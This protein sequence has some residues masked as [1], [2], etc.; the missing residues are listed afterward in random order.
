MRTALVMATAVVVVGLTAGTA[1]TQ[2]GIHRG[3]N[4]WTGRAYT[5]TVGRNPWTGATG[6]QTNTFNPWT[7]TRTVQTG[8]FN[9]WTGT[10]YRTGAAFNPWTNQYRYHYNVRRW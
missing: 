2:F 3:V 5:T 1:S 9:P 6:F 7:G 10:T 8:G 4:P